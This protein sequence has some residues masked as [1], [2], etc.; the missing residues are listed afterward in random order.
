MKKMIVALMTVLAIVFTAGCGVSTQ[1]DE[2][3]LQIGAGP[4]EAPKIKGCVQPGEK[5]TSP[6]NDK[7]ISYPVSGRDYDAGTTEG[8]DSGPIT[9]VSSDNTEM[10]IPVRITWDFASDCKSLEAFYKL[11]NRYG[12]SLDDK[13]QATAGFSKVLDKVLN[14]SLDTTLD[15]IAKNYKWRELYNDAAAQNELQAALDE[16]LQAVVDEV[17]KG[18]FFTNINVATLKKPLPTNTDLVNAIAAEQAAVATAQS[19]EAKA[20][21]TEAQAEAETATAKAEALKQ[22]AIIEGYGSFENY[23]QI[24]AILAGLNPFQPTYVVSGTTPNATK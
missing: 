15:E 4:I 18:E 14:N 22:K 19:A 11:Y 3:K 20:R 10:S 17:A 16:N 6:T 21:A 23:A 24:E 13:G 7:Y 12:A 5:R 8:G 9:V 2:V 1:P